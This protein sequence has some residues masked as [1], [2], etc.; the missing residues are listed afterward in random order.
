METIQIITLAIIQGLTEFLPV[1]SSGHLILTQQV[2]GWA[3]Q[4]Q[5]FDVALHF[6]SVIAVI[7]YFHKDLNNIISDWFK[8]FKTKEQTKEQT[9]DSRLGW[10]IIV[11]T[12]PACIAGLIIKVLLDDAFRNP[13]IVAST[14]IFFGLLLGWASVKFKGKRDIGTLSIKDMLLIGI[15]QAFALIPGTSRSGITITAAL[16]MGLTPVAAA[17]FSFLLSIPAILLASGLHVIK[18]ISSPDAVNWGDMI[19]GAGIAAV[20]AFLCIHLF[21]KLIQKINMVPFVVYRVAMGIY[22]IYLFA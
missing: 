11:G 16:A 15:A 18:I 12:I 10:G 9:D 1:S 3:D 21:L 19:M 20:T 5:A 14:L 4:G 2:L 13:L 22:L 17:R 7:G 6:G 8:S